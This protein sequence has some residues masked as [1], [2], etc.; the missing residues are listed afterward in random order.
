MTTRVPPTGDRAFLISTPLD[1]VAMTASPDE[2]LD[3]FLNGLEF[4]LLA[5]EGR[6][7]DTP[8]ARAFLRDYR[9]VLLRYREGRE[10]PP[11]DLVRIVG[12]VVVEADVEPTAR[13]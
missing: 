7:G 12:R 1:P 6:L 11:A 10:L 3:A 9:R 5:A 8:E 4:A 2:Y 13:N